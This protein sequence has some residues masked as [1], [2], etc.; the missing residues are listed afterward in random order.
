MSKK[1][2][3]KMKKP[4]SR[5]KKVIVGV[6]V[7]VIALGL[8]GTDW[9]EVQRQAE[10]AE[11]AAQ[12]EEEQKAKEEK[13]KEK[14][15]EKKEKQE[16]KKPAK[17]SAELRDNTVMLIRTYTILENTYKNRLRMS[18][19][20]IISTMKANS[21]EASYITIDV[22]RLDDQPYKNQVIKLGEGISAMSYY[23]M[24]DAEKGYI[25]DFDK[26]MKELEQ[27]RKKLGRKLV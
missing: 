21:E 14:K 16:D 11:K 9:D 15:E 24:Y 26:E 6:I 27:L 13:Q 4:W 20:T 2:S 25:T 1:M 7:A 17:M 22:E 19:D 8:L 10:Q 18:D 3:K 12:L 5:K 23:I